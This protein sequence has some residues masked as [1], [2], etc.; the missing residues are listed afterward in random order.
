MARSFRSPGKVLRR[1]R[2]LPQAA[3]K[4]KNWP[5]FV[6]NYALGFTP[7]KPYLLRSGAKVQIGR[8]VDHVPLIE[9]FLREDYGPIA[10]GSV[11]LD[12]GANI[13]AFSV[14]AVTA[15]PGV[16]VYAY[17]PWPEFFQSLKGNLALNGHERAVH[18]FNYAVAGDAGSKD[19]H[20][21]G[22]DFSFPTLV[23]A[24]GPDRL[25][26]QSVPCTTLPEI[27]ATNS[28]TRVDLLKMDCEGAEYEILYST[29]LSVLRNITEV[30]MEYHDL[31]ADERNVRQLKRYMA[32]AGYALTCELPSSPTNGTIWLRR[33]DAED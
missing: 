5:A 6:C 25:N 4:L 33:R 28:L 1:L 30:R 11:V 3:R 16:V 13:G 27:L 12:L 20:V 9:I 8:A 14:Y 31:D 15:A 19:L 10:T 7:R 18:C 24:T 22:T 29:P 2:I 26:T 21:A 32:D 23:G 17:E